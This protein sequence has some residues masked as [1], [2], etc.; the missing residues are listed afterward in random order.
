[1]T[2]LNKVIRSIEHEAAADLLNTIVSNTKEYADTIAKEKSEI[3]LLAKVRDGNK[4]NKAAV[5]KLLPVEAGILS[6]KIEGNLDLLEVLFLESIFSQNKV[7]ADNVQIIADV[8]KGNAIVKKSIESY[9]LEYFL[10][11]LESVW[12]ADQYQ[13]DKVDELSDGAKKVFEIIYKGFLSTPESIE[14]IDFTSDNFEAKNINIDA[15]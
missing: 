11:P 5:E 1:M 12:A 15:T 7:N 2:D 14:A 6:S 8:I 4:V 3:D 13:N 10:V 9:L